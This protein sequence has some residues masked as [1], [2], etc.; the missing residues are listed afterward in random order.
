LNR[1]SDCASSIFVL[2][3]RSDS[4]CTYRYMYTNSSWFERAVLMVSEICQV[5]GLRNVMSPSH[6]NAYA[7]T[8]YCDYTLIYRYGSVYSIHKVG[9]QCTCTTSIYPGRPGYTRASL[10][11]LLTG[12]SI[13]EFTPGCVECR[14]NTLCVRVHA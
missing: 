12:M 11:S 1:G 2:A 8:I 6:A 13:R 14:H 5:Y 9:H 3:I 10:H 7:I 4:V